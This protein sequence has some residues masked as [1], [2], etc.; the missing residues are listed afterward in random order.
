MIRVNLID[1]GYAQTYRDEE[2]CHHNNYEQVDF[3][4]GNMLFSSTRQLQFYKT[5]RRDDL[6]SLLYL[7]IYLLNG[8]R[9]SGLKTSMKDFAKLD[10]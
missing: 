7:L 2:G 6:I 1:F 9:F 5:N 4:Q 8:N 3:F 10:D